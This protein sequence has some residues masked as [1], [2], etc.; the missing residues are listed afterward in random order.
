[1]RNTIAIM[2]AL[3]VGSALVGC[4]S[5]GSKPNVKPISNT[6]NSLAWTVKYQAKCAESLDSCVG[7]YGFTV[8]SDGQFVVGPNA[9]GKTRKAP[10]SQEDF[11]KIS[12]VLAP[13]LASGAPAENR[14][15]IDGIGSDES[16]SLTRSSGS[17]QSIL[18]TEGTELAYTISSE[19]DAKNLLTT[20]RE[21]AGSYYITPFPGACGDAATELSALYAANQKC[22]SDAE[23]AF[24]DSSF[25]I[26]DA[27]SNQFI[28]TDDCKIIK[29]LFVGNISAIKANKAKLAEDSEK[30]ATTC[31]QEVYRS[32][33][34]TWSGINNIANNSPVCK[35][36]VCSIK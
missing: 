21:L 33:C 36:G 19:E 14:V 15:Q 30:L 11:S 31:G 32:G 22:T 8:L 5:N 27:N 13:A 34:T 35:L 3:C 6:Q 4:N 2:T 17:E 26:A 18:K 16:V 20:L 12:G 1:M 7:G 29:P 25:D 28:T 23:C 9:E 10:L 24:V